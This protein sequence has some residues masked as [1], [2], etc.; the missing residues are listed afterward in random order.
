[1]SQRSSYNPQDRFFKKAKQEGFAARSVYKLQ[2][3]DQKFKVFKTGLT[4]L[5]LGA[6]PGSWSQY[7]SQK[8][9]PSGR[10]LG[11][12][13]S[14]VTVSLPNA[15]FIEAD[16]RDL[17]LETIFQEHGFN[18]P[19]DI[20][21]SDMAPKTTGIKSADQ[22]RSLELC[23]LALDVAKRFLKQNGIFICKFF[24]SG[25]FGQLRT[26]IKKEF[27]RV[28]AIKPESTRAISKEI[29]LVGLKKKS[30]PASNQA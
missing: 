14:P 3:I 18:P 6:S 29:F 19:F 22:V 11:V 20:V 13:L 25:E 7:A 1:M 4:V 2:E 30:A 23:E 17:N 27:E 16:L 10:L 9:G 15:V 12:D 21:M 24:Q 5:D 26:A 8:I 28:E